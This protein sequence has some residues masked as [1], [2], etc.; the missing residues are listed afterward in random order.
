MGKPHL[1][2]ELLA[3]E[4]TETTE[5]YTQRKSDVSSPANFRILLGSILTW[6]RNHLPKLR[7][8][9]DTP[10]SPNDMY[11][12]TIG[13]VVKYLGKRGLETYL[14]GN[15]VM[16]RPKFPESPVDGQAWVYDEDTGE[17]KLGDKAGDQHLL[18]EITTAALVWNLPH[19]F[20]WRPNYEIYD[21]DGNMLHGV[22]TTVDVNTESVAF[23]VARAGFVYFT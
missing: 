19:N 3:S 22:R 15:Q 5:V 10:S 2:Q 18:I 8:Q 6:V 20:G 4:I 14:D 16:I 13:G 17:M 21:S 12:Y 1:W 7:V 23:S 9:T 11:E